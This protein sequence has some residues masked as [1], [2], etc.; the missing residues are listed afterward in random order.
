MP[1]E[2]TLSDSDV[3]A[4]VIAQEVARQQIKAQINLE[5]ECHFSEEESEWL[6]TA[7]K[8]VPTKLLPLLGRWLEMFNDTAL[9]IGKAVLKFAFIASGLALI[10]TILH[11]AG[12]LK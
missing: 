1:E 10:L 5:D 12:L 8:Y 9:S 4:I 7:T 6:H 2:R 11:K 3:N